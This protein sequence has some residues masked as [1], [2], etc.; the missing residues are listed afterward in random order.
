MNKQIEYLDKLP[1][2]SER[3]ITLPRRIINDV[4]YPAREV[5]KIFRRKIIC[6]GPPMNPIDLRMRKK[7]SRKTGKPVIKYY[8]VIK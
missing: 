6:S 3:R 2:K 8:G 4:V 5:E 1:S 7:Y